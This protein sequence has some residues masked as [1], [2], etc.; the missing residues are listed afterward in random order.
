MNRLE[1]KDKPKFKKW[2]SNP[3]PTKFPRA[4]GEKVSH[5]KFKKGKGFNSPMEK[6]TCGM[7]GKKQYEECLKGTDNCFSFGE[8]G[9]EIRDCPNMMSQDR[10]SKKAQASVSSDVP[11][12]NR[13]YALHSRGDQE[14]SLTW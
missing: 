3:V 13:F 4:S 8:S 5:L 11:K 6:P 14:T 9:Q 2:G 1:I 7:C 10:G 12:K